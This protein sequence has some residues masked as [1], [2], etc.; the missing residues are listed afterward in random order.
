VPLGVWLLLPFIASHLAPASRAPRLTLAGVLTITLVVLGVSLS[1]DLGSSS[2]DIW[3]GDRSTEK[4]RYDSA[5]VALES[6]TGKL[7]WSFQNVH[8]DLW[9]MDL[10][11]QP[12][13][14]DLRT[15]ETKTPPS[16]CPPRP[17]TSSSST[18]ATAIYW[19]PPRN[20]Q[21]RK[22]RR[23]ATGCRRRSR[24]PI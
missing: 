18:T 17:G 1:R 21:C 23:P 12:S 14:V 16:I 4:E 22:G 8:H 10:P 5:L 9:D 24:F 13:L 20:G 7:R 3:G 2:Q 19:C 6:A 11:S 15:G